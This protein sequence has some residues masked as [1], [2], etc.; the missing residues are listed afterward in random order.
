MSENRDDAT[1]QFTAA[2]PEFGLRGIEQEAGYVHL[3]EEEKQ[4]PEELTVAEA[5]ELY[6]SRTAQADLKTYGPVDKLP[7]NVALTV[8]QA[9][10]I[11]N[12][13]RAADEAQVELEA[14]EKLRKE[15][16]ELRGVKAEDGKEQTAKQESPSTP[17]AD[18][19][20][21]LAIPHVREAVD[22][23]TN[24]T[25]TARQNYTRAVDVAHQF[26]RASF[27][28][29]FPEIAGL[30]VEQ[31]EGAL[32]AMS[33]R[34]PERFN[35]ALSSINRVVQLHAAQEEQQQIRTR[36][37]QQQFETYTKAESERFNEMIKAEPKEKVRAVEA[38]IVEGIKE[39]GGDSAEF[40]ELFK[41]TKLLNSAIA[42]RILYD[43]GKYRMIQNAPKPKPSAPPIPKVQR[44]GTAGAVGDR[45]SA[46]L[47]ELEARLTKTGSI[48]DAA[49]LYRA[50]F[51]KRG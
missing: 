6:N 36:A 40:F 2:E 4:E 50:K 28:E 14:D 46:S 5:A 20:K 17:E 1:G 24:E 10:K 41:S 45:A 38:A 42:Q 7:D 13:R 16:D 18:V 21:F 15:V 8:E 44:P 3:P 47:A 37:E 35:R 39:L 27:I 9:A 49:A 19:E 33:Q 51:G 12:D 11:V 43:F 32:T 31:W 34:E 29:N 26:A 23:L 22:K 48:E 25:E 30:P